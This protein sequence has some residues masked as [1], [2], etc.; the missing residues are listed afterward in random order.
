MRFIGKRSYSLYLWHVLFVS[1]HFSPR[2]EF[3]FIHKWSLQIPCA[4]LCACVSYTFVE[5]P[6]IQIGRRVSE[7]R[8]RAHGVSPIAPS[9]VFIG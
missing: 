6:M 5:Q 9:R 8:N 3:G 1:G 4:F 7:L 2:P